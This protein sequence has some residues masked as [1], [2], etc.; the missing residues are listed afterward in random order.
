M[1]DDE[2]RLALIFG[3]LGALLL[4]LEGVIGLVTGAVL[5]AFGHGFRALGAW[6]HALL[7][8]VVGVIV[9]FFA[10]FGRSRSGDRSVAA[11]VILF[12]IA[13]LGWLVLGLPTGL[14]GILGS[15]LVII[16]GLLFLVSGR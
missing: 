15:I 3:L 8:I 12:A 4:V 13:L 10:V 14:L 16:S 9:G 11:G 6:D 7:L 2:R 5:L 1:A